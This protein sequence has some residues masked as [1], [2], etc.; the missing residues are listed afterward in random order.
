M[1]EKEKELKP[2]SLEEIEELGYETRFLLNVVIELLVKKNIIKEDDLEKL[3]NEILSKEDK[4][5]K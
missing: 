3:Y 2:D 1:A 4:P 5:E